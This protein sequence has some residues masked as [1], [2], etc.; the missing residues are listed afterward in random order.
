MPVNPTFFQTQTIQTHFIQSAQERSNTATYLYNQYAKPAQPIDPAHAHWFQPWFRGDFNAFRSVS[1]F[2]DDLK[3]L[4]MKPF[5][6]TALIAYETL[7][8]ALCIPA[9]LANLVSP[10]NVVTTLLDMVETVL[11]TMVLTLMEAIELPLQIGSLAIRIGITAFNVFGI[12][13]P[14]FGHE[15]AQVPVA[16]SVESHFAVPVETDSELESESEGYE[17]PCATFI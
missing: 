10:T 17:I 14:S 15:Q 16:A 4:I 13:P 5:I 3:S 11:A 9:L 2:S 1:D 6:F 8:F 7:K 12:E